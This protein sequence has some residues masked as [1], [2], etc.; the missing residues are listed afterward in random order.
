MKSSLLGPYLN[1]SRNKILS[2]RKVQP[3][4][5]ICLV[6]AIAPAWSLK[7]G[8]GIDCSSEFAFIVIRH[9]WVFH[10]PANVEARHR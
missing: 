10:L 6:V 1:R 4:R 9:P 8:E 7:M 2:F 3:C 5:W